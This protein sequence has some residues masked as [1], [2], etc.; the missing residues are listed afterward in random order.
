[1]VYGAITGAGIWW[2]IGPGLPWLL[3]AAQRR[4]ATAPL[5]LAVGFSQIGVLALN[6]LSRQIV[7]NIELRDFLDVA[8]EPVTTQWSPLILFL[9]LFTGGL[10]VVTWMLRKAM[11]A[12]RQPVS[13]H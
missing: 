4:K 13:T 11:A 8:R 12:S 7:Q 1:M 5:A 2:T 10:G 9:V 3:I 6:G